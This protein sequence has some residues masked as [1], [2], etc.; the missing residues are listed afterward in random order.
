MEGVVAP[1]HEAPGLIRSRAAQP[2][3]VAIEQLHAIGD[4]R[5]GLTKALQQAVSEI[6]QNHQALAAAAG[7]EYRCR[8]T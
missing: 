1:K 7:I 4:V 3:T 5:R 6:V 8:K 2:V